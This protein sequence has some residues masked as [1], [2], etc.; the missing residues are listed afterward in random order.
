MLNVPQQ[1]VGYPQTSGPGHPNAPYPTYVG[2]TAQG[3][4]TGDMI[5]FNRL[6]AAMRRQWWVV[7]ACGLAGVVLG[8]AYM[9]TAVP[10]YTSS[11]DLLIDKSRS[12]VIDQLTVESGVFQDEAETLS[13]IELLK[14]E[15]IARNVVNR[16]DLSRNPVFMDGAPSMISLMIGGVRRL[17]SLGVSLIADSSLEASDTPDASQAD[18]ERAVGMVRDNIKVE[19]VG[20]TYVLRLYYDSPSPALS[21]EIASAFGAAYLEDQ[22]QSKF[23]ATTRAGNWL[24]D[25]ITELRE[26][27]YEA[28]IAVQAFR[29][30]HNLIAA[31][32]RLVSEQQLSEV[33]TQLIAAQA[34]TAEA[35]ARV[36]QLEALIESGKT[37]AVVNDALV[38]STINAL[39]TRYLNASRLKAE[40][41]AKLGPT[42]VQV[43]RL[44][45][46]MVELERLIF[47]ELER[48]AESYRST[49]NVALSREQSLRSSLDDIL[50]VNVLANTTQVQLRELE[51]EA[52]TFRTLYTSFLRRH[53]ETVQQQTFPISDARVISPATAPKS[54]SSPKATISLA[55]FLTLGLAAGVGVGAFREYRDR[56]FR[57]AD[58]VR[59]EAQTDFLGYLPAI[60]KFSPATE[61]TESLWKAGSLNAY[62]RNHPFTAFSETLRN[63]KVAA[64][65]AL[66]D[67][68]V[69]VIGVVSCLP[70][71]GKTTVST[72]FAN[73][74]AQQGARVALVDGD[75][76]NPGLTRSLAS[77]PKSGLV[78][79]L[80]GDADPEQPLPL[81][82]DHEGKLSVLPAVLNRRVS[83][84][85]DLLASA[86][87]ETVLERLKAANDYIVV[88]LPPTGPVVDAK[89]FARRI[90]AFVFVV[91]WGRTS[92]ML[93]RNTIEHT[94]I[95]RDKCLGIVLNKCDERKM[96]LY[97]SFGSEE[98][99][100]SSQY[101]SYYQS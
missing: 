57:T 49:Y 31:G 96:R 18:I 88:D 15:A 94:P 45:D 92:R 36:E 59:S 47:S 54:P 41:E 10:I 52:E 11:V 13:Q 69:K 42:H 80:T 28:D 33:S 27:A 63:I 23:D 84:T 66:P 5:D 40:I 48:I 29:T 3:D 78:E 99:Y 1:N 101:K 86:R 71:E 79:V 55:L 32:G 89:A 62:V 77:R 83:N 64:D 2:A 74:I 9:A 65:L 75:L 85:S 95:F 53:Q 82:F 4:E 16:L 91:E 6:L 58:Q 93:V 50:G 21:A 44:R 8:I 72:N 7:V 25:R 97:R 20:R 24:Q 98:Y 19:R 38:S 37:D 51:R 46:E 68:G 81:L 61:N 34:A 87:M 14:S 39:R 30:E 56:F 60:R 17:L 76:R 100:Y 35:R 73:L 43:I 67:S 26:Q 12:R 70:S 22:L 90:D